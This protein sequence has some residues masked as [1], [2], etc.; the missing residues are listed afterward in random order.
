MNTLTN[1]NPNNATPS[2]FVEEINIEELDENLLVELHPQL[3]DAIKTVQAE[4][5]G[6]EAVAWQSFSQHKKTLA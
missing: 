2:E 4:K 3:A 1:I 5:L 6:D